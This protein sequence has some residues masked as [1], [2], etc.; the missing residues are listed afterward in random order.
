MDSAH[1]VQ[2]ADQWSLKFDFVLSEEVSGTLG[3]KRP[4]RLSLSPNYVALMLK[5]FISSSQDNST[6]PELVNVDFT[7]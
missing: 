5:V 2:L 1:D 3:I 6:E 7:E 4:V